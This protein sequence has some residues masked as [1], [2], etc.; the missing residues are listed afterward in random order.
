MQEFYTKNKD[1]KGLR[2][3]RTELKMTFFYLNVHNVDLVISHLV[4]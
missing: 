1:G 4:P 2:P 3:C